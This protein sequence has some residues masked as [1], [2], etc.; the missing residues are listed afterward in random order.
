MCHCSNRLFLYTECRTILAG[1]HCVLNTTLFLRTVIVWWLSHIVKAVIVWWTS[2]CSYRLSL[3]AECHTN[4]ANCYYALNVTLSLQTVIVWWT[5]HCSYRQVCAKCDTVVTDVYCVLNDT[6]FLQTNIVCWE[7]LFLY[8]LLLYSKCLLQVVV[9]CQVSLWLAFTG[10]QCHCP[11]TLRKRLH[12]RSVISVNYY[13]I[14][15]LCPF[16]LLIRFKCYNTV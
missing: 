1:C 11:L 6:L 7:S 3:C 13:Y 10:C 15:V 2:H 14:T 16:N 8:W 5:S 9:V 4:L 12:I